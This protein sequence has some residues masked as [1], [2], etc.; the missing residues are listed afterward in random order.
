MYIYV[1]IINAI[2]IINDSYIPVQHKYE[3]ICDF[4]DDFAFSYTHL[5]N[6]LDCDTAHVDSSTKS[7]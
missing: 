3:Y 5:S 1:C 6:V 7:I 4:N 2:L